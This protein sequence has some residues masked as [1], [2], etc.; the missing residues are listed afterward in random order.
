[1]H[2]A[3]IPLTP[4]TDERNFPVW[5]GP[6]AP[7]GHSGHPYPKMLIR[8]FPKEERASWLEKHKRHDRMDGDYWEERCPKVG[9]PVPYEATQELVDAGL[10]NTVGEPLIANTPAE[11]ELIYRAMGLRGPSAPAPVVNIPLAAEPADEADGTM[12][13]LEAE[14][15]RLRKQLAQGGKPAKRKYTRRA[16]KRMTLDEMAAG[17][18]E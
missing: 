15:A 5:E 10:A 17:E 18:A 12:A 8:A 11:E 1:M 7:P 16:P 9:D 6:K 2:P 14:N 13:D 4:Q 3:R